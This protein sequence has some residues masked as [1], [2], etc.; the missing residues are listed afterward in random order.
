MPS[1]PI[2]VRD[3]VQLSL[4]RTFGLCLKGI[5]HRLFR[6]V[7]TTMVIILAV[8]F[9][10]TLLSDSVIAR[11][12]DQGV[13]AELKQARRSA[14]A[15]DLWFGRPD[16]NTLATR[17]ANP[18][19]PLADYAAIAGWQPPRLA[20]LAAA[21]VRERA[22]LGWIDRQ[23][24]GT[25]AMLVRR[26]RNDEILAWLAQSERWNAFATASQRV[27]AD[28]LPLSLD[29]VRTAVDAAP[30]TA[31]E[32]AE[33]V[34]D[35][36]A[37]IDALATAVTQLTSVNDREGWIAWLAEAKPDGVQAFAALLAAHGFAGLHP[38]TTVAD[39]QAACSLDRLY[40]QVKAGLTSEEGRKRWLAAFRTKKTPEEK[41]QQLDD[42]RLPE[43]LGGKIPRP[44]L[45]R[46]DRALD[47]KRGLD[48]REKALA[49]KVDPDG[50]LVSTRQ[51]FLVAI[52]FLVCMVGIANAMLMAI[53]ERFRE[54]AT[55]K[56]LGATDGFILTQ[57]LMEAGIQG[58]A[59]G[60]LGMLVGL[61]LS[62]A[63]G[64]WFFGGH[65]VWYFPA[66]GLLLCGLA[67]I[68]AGLLL[69][70]LASIYPSWLASR[71][72]PMEA[73]RVE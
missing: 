24:A 35:W 55:M 49:G 32:L 59:G 4:A 5:K 45:L 39:L 36:Q 56:C 72:A 11:A 27:R 67:C 20:A 26:A 16:A 38:A 34:R 9:F 53:T 70:T 21:C 54:I 3:Q 44:E 15:A 33:L 8:A 1:P 31:T 41:L 52:S 64:G 57:F 61:L 29:E 58:A 65:L 66:F 18:A 43:V 37:R 62:L 73:M 25:R 60:A 48:A 13:R 46:L 22:I 68:V 51:A 19:T 12:V 17:L 7:L 10:M 6:S 69:A 30:A 42:P 40:D 23:D 28:R 63:K 50:G 14:V 47:D 2:D 71:M